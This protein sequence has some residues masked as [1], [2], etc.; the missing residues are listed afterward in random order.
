MSGLPEW[1]SRIDERRDHA[2][3]MTRIRRGLS[4]YSLAD[5]CRER[6]CDVRAMYRV[7][8][9]GNPTVKS[10]LRL[11]GAVGVTFEWLISGDLHDIDWLDHNTEERNG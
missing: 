5:A 6:K 9:R 4:H 2:L 3:H 1:L 8:D 11:S 10:L 7:T